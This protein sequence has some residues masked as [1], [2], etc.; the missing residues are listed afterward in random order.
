MKALSTALELISHQIVELELDLGYPSDLDDYSEIEHYEDI[1]GSSILGS[2]MC[3][4]TALRILSLSQ[5]TLLSTQQQTSSPSETSDTS[6]TSDSP[7]IGH[8]FYERKRQ[9]ERI[10]NTFDFSTIWSLKLRLCPGWEDLLDILT[11]YPRPMSIKSLEIQSPLFNEF[12]EGHGIIEFLQSFEGLENF[13]LST[14]STPPAF[15]V[16]RA[17]SHHKATLRRFVHHQRWI[18]PN[19]DFPLVEMEADVSDLSL[20]ATELAGFR[21][22]PS[23]NPLN[24]LELTSLG[25]CCSPVTMVGRS[26]SNQITYLIDH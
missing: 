25:L 15:A 1:I 17:V 20:D 22:D 10:S 7:V 5:V 3:K 19:E 2:G 8:P 26:S 9:V 23:Q 18:D 12:G 13:Y 24:E 11:T 21:I 6:D 4:F 16:W 14:G